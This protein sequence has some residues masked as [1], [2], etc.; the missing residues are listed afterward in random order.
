MFRPFEQ[1]N[2]GIAKNYGGTCLGMAI[3][4][5]IVRLMGGEIV[6]DSMPE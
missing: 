5:Q 2:A 1:E 3:T 4:D 6:I